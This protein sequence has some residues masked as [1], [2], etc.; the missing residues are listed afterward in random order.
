V[1]PVKGDMA[2][3]ANEPQQ[4]SVFF[5]RPV[6]PG[7]SDAEAVGCRCRFE[8][9]MEAAFLAKDRGHKDETIVVIA[10]DCP[11][12]EI[13]SKPMDDVLKER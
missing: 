8:V 13:V 7:T 3:A 1:Q 12:H 9:N 11:I 4:V 10:K 5:R 2:S 6:M